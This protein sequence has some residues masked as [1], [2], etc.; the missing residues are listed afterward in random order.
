MLS[1]FQ[2]YVQFDWDPPDY[3]QSPLRPEITYE[4]LATIKT[5]LTQLEQDVSALRVTVRAALSSDPRL[6]NG[7]REMFIWLDRHYVPKKERTHVLI[8]ALAWMAALVLVAAAV[9]L[10]GDA[11]KEKGFQ[12]GKDGG[13]SYDVDQVL[14]RIRR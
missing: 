5:S 2:R 6:Q 3:P 10:Y 8:R 1:G 7:Y 9:G 11:M 14:T 13:S 12:Q 4:M